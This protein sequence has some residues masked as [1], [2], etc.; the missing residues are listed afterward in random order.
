MRRLL[1][2]LGL[3]GSYLCNAQ[4]GLLLGYND[5]H[6]G[7][8]VVLEY[9]KYF[10]KYQ[11][12]IG[13]KYHIFNPHYDKESALFKDRVY[14]QTFLQHFGPVLGINRKIELKNPNFRPEVFFQ[15][16]YTYAGLHNTLFSPF[17]TLPD[18]RDLY[19]YSVVIFDEMHIIENILGVGFDLLITSNLRYYNRFG[20]IGGMYIGLDDQIVIPSE[21]VVLEAGLF[22]SLGLTYSFN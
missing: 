12:E 16:Q 11:I 21:D 13:L 4:S 14:P 20:L 1:L 18:G 6:I 3:F 8:N 9:Y 7:T 15:S 17:S 2:I 5:T 22:F 10:G 19:T